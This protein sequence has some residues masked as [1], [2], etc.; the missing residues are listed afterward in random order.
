MTRI[1]HSSQRGLAAVEFLLCLPL[2]LLLSLPVIDL[3]RVFQANII[4]TNI[5]R[6]GANLAARSGDSTQAIM[7]ALTATAVP[8]DMPANGMI[9]ITKVLAQ[10]TQGVTRNI[11]IAQHR[12]TGGAYA[13]AKGIWHCGEGGSY[14]A[15]DG[16]CAGLPPASHGL[17]THIMRGRLQD[18][19]IAYVVEA[20]Y[21]FP[22]LFGGL[23]LGSGMLLPDFDPDLY[24]FAIF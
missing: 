24:A 23:D 7:N 2:L 20:F 21:R 19:E 16:S 1:L 5:A 15:A 13:P 9:R 11:V 12:W 22:L 10:R 4:L 8:L 3:A 6:E 14:W 17:E 18:G